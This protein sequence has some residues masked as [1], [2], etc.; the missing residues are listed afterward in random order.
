MLVCLYIGKWLYG[1]YIPNVTR[2]IQCNC[3]LECYCIIYGNNVVMYDTIV[4]VMNLYQAWTICV[5]FH[6]EYTQVHLYCNWNTQCISLH[7]N[8]KFIT[9][10]INFIWWI[11]K[12]MHLKKHLPHVQYMIIQFYINLDLTFSI[13]KWVKTLY[14]IGKSLSLSQNIYNS[15]IFT[16][17]YYVS[18][19]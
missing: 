9:Q 19:V 14:S 3:I 4:G 16:C 5:L 1:I 10:I 12:I 18:V 11:Q 15:V 8:F 13:E 6:F 17:R 7:F 2:V